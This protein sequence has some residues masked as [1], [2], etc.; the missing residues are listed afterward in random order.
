MENTF[1][2]ILLAIDN[3][4]ASNT[5]LLQA[6]NYAAIF[7]SELT[8]L[9][10][11]QGT[12]ETFDAAKKRI[13]D[14]TSSRGIVVELAE[15]KGKFY[16]EVSKFEKQ[17]DFT[18]IILGSRDKKGWKPFWSSSDIFKVINSST[19]PVLSVKSNSANFK[20]DHIVL[21][22]ADSTKTRQK[23]PYC[24]EIAKRFGAT[25]HLLGISSSS[26]REVEHK[27]NSYLRQTEKYLAERDLN[28]V[29]E[30]SFGNKVSDGIMNYAKKVNAGL[31][32]IM[33]DT[34]SEGLFSD[35]YS[36]KLVYRCATPIL[37]IH[38]RDT[39]LTGQAGY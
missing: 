4:D 38:S 29:T 33:T 26:G 18:L 17:G 28:Y 15:R 27:V 34:E 2:K 39:R 35:S 10:V 11:S 22:L 30:I 5:A 37:S 9:F 16:D 24:A 36:Q 7:K 14:F 20:L 1:N 3:T 25:I 19:S 8:V 6:C 12:S 31:V 21:P 32:L 13:K 23:V